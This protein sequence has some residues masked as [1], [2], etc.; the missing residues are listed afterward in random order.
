MATSAFAQTAI[1]SEN[2]GVGKA[3][4][5]YPSVS[6]YTGYQ[7]VSPVTFA[8]NADIRVPASGSTAAAYP[9]ASAA[10]CVF[11]G[12]VTDATLPEKFVTISGIDTQNFTNITLSFG[13]YNGATANPVVPKVEVSEDGTTWTQLSYTRTNTS[14]SVWE[15]ATPSGT[16]PATANLRIR[17]TNPVNSNVGYRIDDIKLEGTAASLGT[18]SSNKDVFTIY[19]TQVSNG[20]INVSSS[21]NGL[22]SVKIYDASSKLVLATKTQKEVNVA[23][24]SKGFYVLNV[25]ENGVVTSKKF[26]IK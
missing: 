10:G 3:S 11:L 26:M 19:P 15:L 21:K 13:H 20:I 17:F 4:S 2:F 12:A 18:A 14:A 23:N 9:N 1:S 5:P 16:I 8:G 7:S 24:L 6:A 22:K 25:E